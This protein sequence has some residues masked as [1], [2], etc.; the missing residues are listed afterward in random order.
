[1]WNKHSFYFILLLLLLLNSFIDFFKKYNINFLRGNYKNDINPY[2]LY[3][4][5]MIRNIAILI[6]SNL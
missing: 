6:I 1:M 5:I 4:T 3:P 2:K